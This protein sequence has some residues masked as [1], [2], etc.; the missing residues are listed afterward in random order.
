M[1]RPTGSRQNT[2]AFGAAL[3]RALERT[4][5][6]QVDLAA[7]TQ[8]SSQYINK[9]IAGRTVS[10]GWVNRIARAL[11]LEEE[12]R[13]ELHRAAARTAGY[14]LDLTKK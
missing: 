9:I 7:A 6:R 4:G 1:S 2:S 8:V 5:K 12:S 3:E 10:P 13:V 14:E 11:E